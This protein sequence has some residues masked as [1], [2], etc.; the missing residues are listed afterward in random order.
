MFSSQVR[1]KRAVGLV[2]LAAILVLFLAFNRFPKLDVV[3]EDLDAVTAP[4]AQCFQ[5]FCIERDPGQSFVTRWFTFSITY[6]RLV[7]IGMTFAFVVA[8]LAEAMLFPQGSG[9]LFPSGSMFRRTLGGAMAGPVMNL[10]SACI[11]PVSSAFR[12]RGAGIEGTIAMVQGSATMNVPALAMVFFVFTPLLGASRLVLAVVGALLIGPLVV[13]TVRGGA[14]EDDVEFQPAFGEIPPES[15]SWSDAL[16]EGVRDWAKYSLGYL[17]RLG[18]IMVIAGF[19]SGLVL[20]WINPDI[21]ARFL[22]NDLQGVAIAATFGILINVPLLFE[23]P[24]VALLLLLGMG[25]APA[26]TLLFTA[27]A[28][29]PVTFWGLAKLMPK[30]A[31]AMFA[32]STWVLGAIGGVGV[33]AI[34]TFVW[35][36]EASDIQVRYGL[37]REAYADLVHPETE[38][39]DKPAFVDVTANSGIDF[40]HTRL[41]FDAVD[42]GAGSVVFDFNSD[43]LHDIYVTSNNGP[44]ALY[45]NNGDGTFTDVAAAARVEDKGG[46]TA[47][48]ACA[49][50]YDNDGDPDLY[51]A[52]FGPSRFYRNNG[53][54]TFSNITSRALGDVKRLERT[55]GCAWGDYDRDGF[56]DLIVVSHTRLSANVDIFGVPVDLVRQDPDFLKLHDPLVLYHN[57]GDGTFED[58]SNLLGDNTSPTLSGPLGNMWGS[59]FQPGWIDYDNDG[60]SDIYVVNDLGDQLHP[61]VLWRNDGPDDAGGWIFTDVSESSGT[62]VE[63]FGM[64]LAV[65]D[66]NLDG[67]LDLFVTNIGQNVLLKNLGPDDGF[68]IASVEARTGAAATPDGQRV[69]WG[70]FFF[71]YDNDLDEDLYLVSGFLNAQNIENPVEQPNVLL[72][73]NG[74]GTF[75][76]VSTGSGTEDPGVGRGGVYL[77]YDNDGCLDIFVSNLREK[78]KLLRNVCEPGNN[79]LEIDLVG[80]HSNRDGIGAR[81]IVETPGT[82]QVREV[83]AGSSQIGQHMMTVH[84]GVGPYQTADSVTVQWP[85]GHVQV[86]EDVEVN[87][88][89]TITEPID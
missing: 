54:G 11:V 44:N 3:G 19:A 34:G 15:G 4:Q 47:N 50:D 81:V 75:T 69:A 41:R 66:Y 10:C 17:V 84:L 7:A 70:T 42:V 52:H 21:V 9:Q 80:S 60:D 31:V 1:K 28:G 87:Q 22:G 72:R 68:E 27:A 16:I 40:L 56:L 78:A 86:F 74:D 12:R 64:G 53:D 45:R 58:T 82:T 49:A 24:L 63:M 67:H 65:G 43:T 59:G 32:G 83:A 48:G 2:L 77:D 30:R 35:T 71:D 20:Q 37:Q 39:L 85:G 76:D 5:G 33:L 73:N 26:A 8:G 88:R 55:T 36:A 57:R 46:G 79:W 18:P 6:L 38:T 62:G 61:N 23:I 51:V 25:T 14:A 29:G 89:V 13:K